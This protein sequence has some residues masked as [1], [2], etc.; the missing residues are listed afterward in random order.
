MRIERHQVGDA[1]LST[2]AHGFAERIAGDV[3]RMQHDPSP[4]YGWQMVAESFLDYLGARSVQDRDLRGRDAQVAFES[5]AQAAVGALELISVPGGPA[6]VSIDYTGTGVSYDG[7]DGWDGGGA[8]DLPIPYDAVPYD[9]GP[10]DD[11][12]V[13]PAVLPPDAPAAPAATRAPGLHTVGAP[14]PAPG[15][16]PLDALGGG[17]PATHDWL[18]AFCLA[19]IANQSDRRAAAFIAAATPRAGHED[20]ADIALVHAL[21]AYAFGHV[22]PAVPAGAT[23]L[24]AAGGLGGVPAGVGG[25]TGPEGAPRRTPATARTDHEKCAVIDAVIGRLPEGTDWPTYRAALTTLRALAAGDQEAFAAALRAQ[26]LLHRELHQAFGDPKPHTL[27]PLD[28]IALAAM[29]RR[30]NG[31]ATGIDSPYLPAAPVS[32]FDPG[33]PR[34]RAYG[35]DKRPDALTALAAGPLRVARPPHPRALDAEARADCAELAREQWA[36]LAEPAP[37]RPLHRLTALMDHQVRLFHL[38]AASDSS[39]AGTGP[40]PSGN[41]PAGNPLADPELTATAA[42]AGAA[43]FRLARTAPGD[44]VRVTV[45][46]LDLTLVRSADEPVPHSLHWRRAVALALLTGDRTALADCVLMPPEYFSPDPEQGQGDPYAAAL[47][48]YLRGDDP[49]PATDRA[50][51]AHAGFPSPPVRLL[52]QLVT[53]DRDGFTLALADELEAHRDHWSVADRPADP[54]AALNLDVLGLVAHARRLPWPVPV[55]SAYL[56]LSP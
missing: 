44:S 3:H 5:A 21:M 23:A 16:G 8:L 39:G 47:H 37:V 24:S 14:A 6:H 50:L 1:A 40:G 11:G 53:G 34:V 2:A 55:L 48:A 26:L 41:P 45:G 49:E 22:E 7:W 20:R 52:S 10:F 27:L 35:R 25:P 4:A 56:P 19:F 12:P 43:A 30:W 32:G 33:P 18:D 13:I 54:E 28:A 15:T 9:A 51:R 31:W 29:A 36:H 46:P 42:Q 38:H 17:V